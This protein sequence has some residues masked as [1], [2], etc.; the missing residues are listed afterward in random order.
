M[1]QIPSEVEQQAPVSP[2]DAMAFCGSSAIPFTG[3]GFGFAVGS[4]GHTPLL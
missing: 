4:A 1:A 3:G 2:F